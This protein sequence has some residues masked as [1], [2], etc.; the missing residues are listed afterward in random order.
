MTLLKATP[1]PTEKQVQA[2]VKA[3]FEAAGAMVYVLGTRRPRGDYPGT[4]QTPGLPDLYAVHPTAG[5]WWFECK[6]PGGKLSE[7]QATFGTQHWTARGL[8]HYPLHHWGA[9]ADA[10]SLL[11]A[12]GLGD[13]VEGQFTLNARR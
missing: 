8:P 7:P 2:A 10:E 1:K 12:L 6:V 4:C 3:L 11:A 13:Y 5:A 9:F